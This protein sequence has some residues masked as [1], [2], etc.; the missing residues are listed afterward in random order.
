MSQRDV[1]DEEDVSRTY[2]CANTKTGASGSNR[3][4]KEWVA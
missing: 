4:T 3:T 1:G 2:H